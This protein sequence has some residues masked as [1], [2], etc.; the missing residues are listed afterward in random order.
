MGPSPKAHLP[1]PA[2][3]PWASL[4]PSP[5]SP[6]KYPKCSPSLQC[7]PIKP[8]LVFILHSW[9]D[10]QESGGRG[11]G[12]T[13]VC[14]FQPDP[15]SARPE[16]S[17]RGMLGEESR[18]RG[19][20]PQGPLHHP[21]WTRCTREGQSLMREPGGPPGAISPAAGPFGRTSPAGLKGAPGGSP[22][23]RPHHPRAAGHRGSETPWV[24]RSHPSAVG[25]W[26][27]CP[28]PFNGLLGLGRATLPAPRPGCW[29][30]ENLLR[31]SH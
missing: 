9:Q 30:W 12:W 17:W 5:A 2:L 15:P 26:I 28:C 3:Q 19:A 27:Y 21:P 24:R 22:G 8:H 10:E 23:L 4:P 16:G 20:S 1:L 31:W 14:A 13:A 25:A 18:G 29:A 7:D 11:L 6:G